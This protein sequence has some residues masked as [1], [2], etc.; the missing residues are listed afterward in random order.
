MTHAVRNARAPVLFF[1]AENDFD[2]TP[3]SVLSA[4]MKAAGKESRVL[5]YPPSGTSARD[6]HSFAYRG[7]ATWF[8]DVLQFL[9]RHCRS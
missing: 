7:S 8:E 3:T 1:Q 9:E 2:L 6:G 5:I 4:A